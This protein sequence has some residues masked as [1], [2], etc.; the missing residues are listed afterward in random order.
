ML[1][2]CS[3]SPTFQIPIISTFLLRTCQPCTQWLLQWFA[4][5][6]GEF[7]G[8]TLPSFY[9]HFF[10]ILHQASLSSPLYSK[11][12]VFWAEKQLYLLIPSSAEGQFSPG[13]L[14]KLLKP[15]LSKTLTDTEFQGGDMPALILWKAKLKA[16]PD[17]YSHLESPCW[18]V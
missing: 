17:I 15:K 6:V 18:Y 9:M 14:V 10:N 1:I 3:D 7:L 16:H 4:C 8:L 5:S 2:Y 13:S 11:A 12:S